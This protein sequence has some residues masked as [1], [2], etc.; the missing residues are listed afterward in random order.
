MAKKKKQPSPFSQNLEHGLE[1]G[2]RAALASLL[3]AWVALW[4]GMDFPIYAVIAAIVVTDASPEVTRR[5]GLLRLVGNIIGAGLG[6]GLGSLLG[7]TPLV[8]AGGVLLA[9]LLCALTGLKD[10]AKITGYITGIV[11][12]FHGDKP[13]AYAWARFVETSI[14]LG[15]AILVGSLAEVLGKFYKLRTGNKNHFHHK[16]PV[17]ATKFTK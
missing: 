6:G 12:L 3:S 2:V 9:I 4:L 1:I 16:P 11:I 17:G 5:T 8:M 7:H 10:A 15:F 14:G 13:W